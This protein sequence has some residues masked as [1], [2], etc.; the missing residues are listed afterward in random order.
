L[1]VVA[2]L[3]N[4]G[5][6]ILTPAARRVITEA[7]AAAQPPERAADFNQAMIELGATVC[8]PNGMPKCE[9]CPFAAD[10]KARA[11]GRV[12]ELPVRKKAAPRKIEQRTV[13]ILREGDRV[14]ICRR[15][16]SGLLAGLFEPPCLPGHVSE[17]EL[18]ALLA[19]CGITPLYLTPLEQAKHIFTHL[20]WHMKGFEVILEDGA[21]EKIVQNGT[22]K[23]QSGLFLAPR[24][25]IDGK[26]AL[27]SA[28]RAYRPYM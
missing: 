7:V 24:E 3:C 1:R 23:L 8:L 11:Y 21:F 19:A 10:C 5:E 6:D 28:Y 12:T 26:Y 22:G 9:L 16:E 15:P 2:R 14:A 13:L 17:K 25:E 4:Y 20:E 27:P 18:R